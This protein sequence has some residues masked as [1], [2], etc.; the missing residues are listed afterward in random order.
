MKMLQLLL[1]TQK[2]TRRE[3]EQK[4]WDELCQMAY[5]AKTGDIIELRP[6]QI[7]ILY[8]DDLE[9][10]KR[11]F[12]EQGMKWVRSVKFD[13]PIDVVLGKDG[14]TDKEDWYLSDGHHRLFAA[15]KLHKPTIKAKVEAINLK[16]IEKLL[17]E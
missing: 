14:K 11:L 8:R 17:K 2:Y 10:P 4:D 5:G 15:L 16:A 3:L 13:E 7:K 12:Q 9:N 1:E 6:S